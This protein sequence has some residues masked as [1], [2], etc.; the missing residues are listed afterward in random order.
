MSS[1]VPMT[2]VGTVIFCA[3]RLLVTPDHHRCDR[4]EKRGWGDRGVRPGEKSAQR[5]KIV[6]RFAIEADYMPLGFRSNAL[7]CQI[8]IPCVRSNSATR[9]AM[10]SQ[11]VR[12]GGPNR[13][14]WTT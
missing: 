9:R 7:T 2:R 8:R 10:G 4:A 12:G 3:L 11:I 1:A 6:G 14:C 5:S 13:P